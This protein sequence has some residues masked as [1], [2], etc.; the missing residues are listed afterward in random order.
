MIVEVARSLAEWFND[1]ANGIA[2]CLTLVPRESGDAAPA[3]GTIAAA[4]AN[5]LVSQ[6]QFPSIPGIAVN[7][8]VIDPLDGANNTVTGDG[9]AEVLVRIARSDQDPAVAATE[10][11][12]ILRAV[13][14]SWRR[15]HRTMHTRNQVQIYNLDHLSIAPM[16]SPLEDAIVTGAANGKV[17]FRDLLAAS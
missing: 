8:K 3:V 17:A 13:L 6:E 16:W 2:A 4:T 12:Y 9:V 1:P 5:G 10:T 15:Y 11:S 14:M 7:V